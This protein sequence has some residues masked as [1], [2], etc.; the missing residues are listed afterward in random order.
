MVLPEHDPMATV[1]ILFIGNSAKRMKVEDVQRCV[2]KASLLQDCTMV[3]GRN[4]YRDN[5]SCYIATELK[6]YLHSK[7]IKPSTGK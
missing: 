3:K 5:G 7:G 4:C 2:E 1:G 6:E